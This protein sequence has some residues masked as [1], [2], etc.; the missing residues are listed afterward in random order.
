MYLMLRSEHGDDLQ[1]LLETAWRLATALQVDI[2]I[3][4]GVRR[5]QIVRLQKEARSPHHD[6]PAK[7]DDT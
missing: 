7:D 3:S 5:P 2:G 6:D 4:D 1:E